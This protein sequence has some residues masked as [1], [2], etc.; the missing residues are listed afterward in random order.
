MSSPA[1]AWKLSSVGSSRNSVTLQRG[2]G[3][4][5]RHQCNDAGTNHRGY[6]PCSHSPRL[7]LSMK[8]EL[9]GEAA[10]TDKFWR[11]SILSAGVDHV[12]SRRRLVIVRRRAQ[13]D[14]SSL[15]QAEGR[16]PGARRGGQGLHILAPIGSNSRC[17]FQRGARRAPHADR[18]KLVVPLSYVR[19]ILGRN[20]LG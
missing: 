9:T 8:F 20:G 11:C 3:P 15:I 18:I 12:L 10:S 14:S 7:T 1:D 16:Q 4:N 19:F 5:D 13:S 2:S 17:A 6:R